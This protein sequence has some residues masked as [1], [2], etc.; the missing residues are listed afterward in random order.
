MISFD[1]VSHTYKNIFTN[2][3][4]TSA[5]TLINKFKKKFDADFYAKKVA[6]KEGVTPEEIKKRWKQINN[7]SKTRGSNIHAAIDAYNK[8]GTTQEGFE[9]IIASLAKLN[10][11]NAKNSKCEELVY[12]HEFKLAGTADVIEDNGASFNVYDFKT[13]KK[14]NLTSDYKSFLLDP[15]SHM[16]ECEYTIYSLQLSLYAF[17]YRTMTGKHVG[18]LGIVY[19]DSSNNFNVYHTPY[20]YSDILKLLSYGKN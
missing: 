18:K 15:V 17:M 5:T 3:D 14:F 20:L 16:S 13:N 10:L 1:K 8:S 6:S 9:E 4:Y 12:N 7:D 11:Y 19:L 2:E